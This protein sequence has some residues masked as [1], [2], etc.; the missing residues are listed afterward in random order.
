VY[1]LARSNERSEAQDSLDWSAQFIAG[2]PPSDRDK[3]QGACARAAAPD[4]SIAKSASLDPGL[5]AATKPL[6]A[7]DWIVEIKKVWARD[8]AGTLEMARVV[9]TA[10]RHLRRQYGQ[11]SRLWTSG[12]EMPISKSTADQLAVIGQ[13]MGGMD[14]QTSENLPRGWNILFCL[15]ALGRETLQQLIYQKVVHPKLTLRQAKELVT[16]LNGTGTQ[17]RTRKTSVRAWL[18]RSAEFVV[19]NLPDW[20]ADM[21][22][23]AT[24]ELT[25][26]IEQI[27]AESGCA[28]EKNAQP[29]IFDL[30]IL[31]DP[32][33]KL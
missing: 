25:R 15:A 21:R 3:S 10:K 16:R 22:K 30:C 6:T 11:W 18:R 13:R 31:A 2:L 32:P 20:S 19:T 27:G 5:G 12:Q 33:N 24:E 1:A 29:E 4:G 8:A 28:S 26:L 7:A 14:S 9:N 17:A 23:L